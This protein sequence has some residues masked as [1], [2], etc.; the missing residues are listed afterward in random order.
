MPQSLR[1]TLDIPHHEIMRF[2]Q[3]NAQHLKVTLQDGRTVQLPLNNFRPFVSS[4][5]LQGNFEVKFSDA[6][7]L[8]SLKKIT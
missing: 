5:G 2:Y 7:K 1:F 6:F 3:G 4:S 8:L